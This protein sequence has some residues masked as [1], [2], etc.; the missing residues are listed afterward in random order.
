LPRWGAR[1]A[2]SFPSYPSI[3]ALKG[4]L[5]VWPTFASPRSVAAAGSL[6]LAALFAGTGLAQA[7]TVPAFAYSLT[8]DSLRSSVTG[9]SRTGVWR[10][11]VLAPSGD[12]RVDF[13]LRTG[14]VTWSGLVRV[15]YRQGYSWSLV[16]QRRLDD[17]LAGGPAVAACNAGVC[18]ST[19]RFV[20]PVNGNA[21][22]SVGVSLSRDGTYRVS[23]GV[24][25]ATEA[26]VYGSWLSSASSAVF[27]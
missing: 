14:D 19:S 1:P 5:A 2:S 7:T 22:F 20:L 13:I 25:Q 3:T 23:G 6:S 17:A 15:S 9:D 11:R 18:W 24:R 10:V 26:F 21:R 4:D 12:H 27:H 16:S 8:G